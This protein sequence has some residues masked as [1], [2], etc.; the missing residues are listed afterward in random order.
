M[1]IWSFIDDI[2]FINL[3]LD[4]YYGEEKWPRRYCADILGISLSTHRKYS[5]Q[6]WSLTAEEYFY[7]RQLLDYSHREIK[8]LTFN[9]GYKYFAGSN[10]IIKTEIPLI[11][12]NSKEKEKKEEI[13]PMKFTSDFN[14]IYPEKNGVYMLGNITSPANR[15]NEQYFLI[16]VGKSTNLKNRISSYKGMNPFAALI[17]IKLCPKSKLDDIESFWHNKL[18]K[19]GHCQNG[20]EWYIVP[21]FYYEKFLTSGFNT[22]C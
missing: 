16:K 3:Q 2:H 6:D 21:K 12:E 5:N 8:K 22:K 15:P 9:D 13:L 17:D 1:R 10:N 19:I 7:T 20:T 4:H 14:H 11:Q 18:D